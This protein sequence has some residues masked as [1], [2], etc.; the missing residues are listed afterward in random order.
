M[1]ILYKKTLMG[2]WMQE[3]ME[4]DDGSG[5]TIKFYILVMCK[6]NKLFYIIFLISIYNK[7]IIKL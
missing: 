2:L 6:N 7:M 5:H 1:I 4:E 3:N